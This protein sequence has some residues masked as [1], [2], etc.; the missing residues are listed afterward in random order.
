MSGKTIHNHILPFTAF[1]P[2]VAHDPDLRP[3]IRALLSSSPEIESVEDI[4][5]GENPN[6]NFTLFSGN[7]H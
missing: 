5:V 2:G 6:T 7:I 1:V 4:I 3:G